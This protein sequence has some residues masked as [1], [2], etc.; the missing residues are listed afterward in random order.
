MTAPTYRLA[1]PVSTLR[2]AGGDLQVGLDATASGVLPGA[3]EG[4]EAALRAFRRW[5][6]TREVSVLTG[7]DHAWLADAAARLAASGVLTGSRPVPPG[8]PV[9]VVGGGPAAQQVVALLADA[10]VAEFR[11]ADTTPGD[12]EVARWREAAGGARLTVVDHWHAVLAQ[13]T[14][15]VVVAPRTVEPD[16]A[17]TDQL[18]RAGLA[19]LV[20]RLE[21]E[22]AVVGPF[23]VP[24]HSPCVRCLDLARCDLDREWPLLLAQLATTWQESGSLASAWASSTAAAHALAWLD[25]G[26]VPAVGTTLELP[27]DTLAL[28]T[29]TWAAHPRCGCLQVW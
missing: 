18:R 16:R 11:A 15:L 25:R 21:P 3:P 17:L 14:P 7:V 9:A 2:R 23:V 27:S 8:G 20:V 10:G 13:P 28:E 6:T 5:H 12:P 26:Q 4:A 1:R 22:R 24:G 29:R 19:H